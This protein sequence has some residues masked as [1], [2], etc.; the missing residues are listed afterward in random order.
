MSAD[1]ATLAAKPGRQPVVG[2]L[3]GMGPEATVELMRRVIHATPAS[4][5]ADHIRMIVDNNPKVP[6]RIKALIEGSGADPA[7]VLAA[8]ASGLE[9]AG[10]DFLVIP[11][12]TAHHYLPAVQA[13]VAIPVLDMID[14]TVGQLRALAARPRTIGLLASPAVRITGLFE[15]R[16]RQAGLAVIYPEGDHD[17]AV[18]DLIRAVKAGR[19]TADLVESYRTVAADLRTRG[20]EALVI[21]CTELSVLGAPE[22]HDGGPVVDTLDVLVQAIVARCTRPSGEDDAPSRPDAGPKV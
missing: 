2:V 6:S 4:D 17:R 22:G 14:L 13:A 18:L 15:A 19:A 20:A 9:R 21:A 3:G 10:A 16:C 8:M 7:P 11:C 1:D 12:N 5:D